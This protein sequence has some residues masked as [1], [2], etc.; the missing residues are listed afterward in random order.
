MA[1]PASGATLDTGHSLYTSLLHAY[2]MLE[3]SGSTT[4]DS[5]SGNTLTIGGTVSWATDGSGDAILDCAGG[6]TSQL[7]PASDIVLA[8]ATSW[9]VA[10]RAKWDTA[11]GTLGGI[12]GASSNYIFFQSTSNLRYRPAAGSG[13]DSN[14]NCGADAFLTDANYLLVFNAATPSLSL[15]R[16]GTLVLI[17]TTSI[18]GTITFARLAGL[19][20]TTSFALAG[21][22]TYFYV[23]NGRAL[24]ATD[25]SNLHS[26]PYAFFSPA[27]ATSYTFTGP[28]SG[29]EGVASTNFTVTPNGDAD[30]VVITPATDG[31][32]T[33]SPTSVTISGSSAATF[34]YTPTN[35][36]GSPHTLSVTNDGGLTNPASIDYTVT[37]ATTIAITSPSGVKCYQRN[38][39]NQH[40]ITVSGTY[41]GAPTSIEYRFAGGSWATLDAA[42]TGGTFSGSATL[43]MGQGTIDVRFSNST[44]VTASSSTIT[45]G[46]VFVIAGQSNAE[47]RATNAQTK[48]S[49][50]F[51]LASFRADD[52][53]RLNNSDPTD[54]ATASGS[55]WPLLAEMI[56]ADQSCPVILITCATGGTNLVNGSWLPPT[57]QYSGM[58]QQ[59]TDSGVNS[60]KAILWYQGESDVLNNETYVDYK[61]ALD[62]F[63]EA[64]FADLP[65]APKTVALQLGYSGGT[66]ND[67]RRAVKDLWDEGGNVLG[68]PSLYDLTSALHP[69][70]DSLI[71][72][73]ARR[74]WAA[75]KEHYYGGASESGRGPQLV[76]ATF[77]D[78][79]TKIHCE[80]SQ[81]LKT[82]LTFATQAW[83]VTD[84]VGTVTVSSVVYHASSSTAVTLTLASA[85]VGAT[86]ISLGEDTDAATRVVPLGPDITLP[87]SLGTINLPAETILDYSVAEADETAPTVLSAVISASGT[88]CTVAFTEP[89][90]PVGGITGFSLSAS[91]GAL[92]IPAASR[93]SNTS[94]VFAL[95]RR[96]LAGETVTLSYSGGNVTDSATSPNL[97]APIVDRSVTNNSTQTEGRW[98]PMRV[99]H[100]MGRCR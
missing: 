19:G 34:T 93:V 69:T 45:V 67:I 17:D 79:R 89:I 10:F 46:D 41:S 44:G 85:A 3:G 25:A 38:G 31:T 63:A 76:S 12:A 88:Y 100:S 65:G 95:S 94:I 14:F 84:S 96:V 57:G 87:A 54:T 4:A 74:Y 60:V 68:G 39:S 86:T 77:S 32:G 11:T 1:K 59:V 56:E 21:T 20:A 66:I 5:R 27:G 13:S 15:Y 9:S 22:M 81:V 51:T 55:I 82:G 8:H 23:W 70:S 2:A 37:S 42:P 50:S 16:N 43:A 40:S 49:G 33:F 98:Y 35:T 48:A 71:Q 80:F 53:W 52:V 18:D 91:G 92:T 64:A 30:G 24:N 97:L 47:G 90:L 83:R 73:T 26:D 75:L 78:G 99:I 62:A 36:A 72:S 28:T 7:D 58:L 6:S 29:V 61:A